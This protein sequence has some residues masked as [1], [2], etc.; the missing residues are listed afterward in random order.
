MIPKT[1]AGPAAFKN[2][3]MYHG[4]RWYKR[5]DNLRAEL[6]FAVNVRDE[7]RAVAAVRKLV[8]HTLKAPIELELPL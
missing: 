5:W 8:A 6:S 3:E 7:D 2:W 1:I 4:R